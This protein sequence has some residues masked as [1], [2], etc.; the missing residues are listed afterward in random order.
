MSAACWFCKGTDQPVS[1]CCSSHQKD[2]CHPCY[3]RLHFVEVC[4]CSECEAA[5]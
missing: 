4:N 5:S 1:V 3:R 2:L